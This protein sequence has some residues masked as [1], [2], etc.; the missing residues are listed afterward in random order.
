MKIDPD[1]IPPEEIKD[2]F[3]YNYLHFLAE[4]ITKLRKRSFND[5]QLKE[6]GF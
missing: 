3:I 1:L 6:M 4:E 5:Q 2:E